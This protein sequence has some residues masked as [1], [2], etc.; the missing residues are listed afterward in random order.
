M[1]AVV[2]GSA[3]EAAQEA[4]QKKTGDM[5]PPAPLLFPGLE[6]NTN[7]NVD[8]V[9]LLYQLL[10]NLQ[11]SYDFPTSLLGIMINCTMQIC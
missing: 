5:Q 9:F 3:Q 2:R 11:S 6:H 10:S 7:I 8:V 1:V 4:A